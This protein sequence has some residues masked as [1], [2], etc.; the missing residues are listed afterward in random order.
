MAMNPTL[1]RIALIITGAALIV[2]AVKLNGLDAD[3]KLILLGAGGGL[4]LGKELLEKTKPAA[5]LLA[6][7]ALSFALSACSGPPPAGAAATPEQ[8]SVV[9][10]RSALNDDAD[11]LDFLPVC[12]GVAIEAD[13]IL[14]AGHCASSQ[15]VLFVDY[16]QWVSTG[17]AK[18]GATVVSVDDRIAVLRPVL[19]LGSWSHRGAPIDGPAVLVRRFE[20]TAVTLS[21]NRVD[22]ALEHGDSGSGVFQGGLLVGVIESCDAPIDDNGT[23]CLPTGG[24]FSPVPL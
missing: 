17:S 9:L 2:L 3:T 18:S 1:Q 11:G 23:A 5:P 19:P 4:I 20:A 10:L 8:A 22:A 24:V 14:T 15:A 16:A 21:G 13:R 6:L 12:G 7:L